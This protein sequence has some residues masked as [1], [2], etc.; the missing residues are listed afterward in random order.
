LIPDTLKEMQEDEEFQFTVAALKEMGQK[1]LTREE[2]KKR[3]RALDNLG[4][5]SFGDFITTKQGGAS[6]RVPATVFQVNIGLYC[7]QACAHCHVESSP[8]R[9]EM[10]DEATV[11]RCLEVIANSPSIQTVD[12]TGGA[13]ELNANF[14]RLVEGARALGKETID[15]CNLTVLSEPGQEDLADF[16]ASNQV[17]VV[18][19]LPCYS[20]KN[21]NTQRGSGVFERSI[22]GLQEL[23][24]KGYGREALGLDL[25]YNPIGAFL[26]PDQASLEEKYKQELMELFGIQFNNLFTVTNMPIKR[27]ADFLHRR[28][29]LEEYMSLLVRNFNSS[30][31]PGMMCT[32]H[33]NVSWDGTMYDCD[34]NQQLD[35]PAER[36][37][38]A[39]LTVFDIASTTELEQ[40]AI[41]HDSHCFGCTAGAGS[42]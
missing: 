25:V 2:K 27:F 15:R 32:N 22:S 5:P 4:V 7:N 24:E 38:N 12:I 10:M 33:I 29:E 40:M 9:T 28:G 19:S 6:Q 42:S 36:E 30:T 13:P 20:A 11:D 31:L 8:K 16:L 39:Q 14:R 3:A 35:M 21:V 34:F 26:P 37:G 1:K 17:R 23:N 18:A 41:K